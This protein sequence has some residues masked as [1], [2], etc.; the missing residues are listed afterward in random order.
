MQAQCASQ[1]AIASARTNPPRM[2]L[3]R[4]SPHH[5][6]RGQLQEA[7]HVIRDQREFWVWQ[8]PFRGN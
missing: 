2:T 4:P 6:N 1:N 8:T 5:N 3:E 7:S